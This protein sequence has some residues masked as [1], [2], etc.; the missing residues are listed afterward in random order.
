MVRKSKGFF[1]LTKVQSELTMKTAACCKL[2]IETAGTYLD[3]LCLLPISSNR[4]RVVNSLSQLTHSSS[5]VVLVF[6]VGQS[7]TVISSSYVNCI[8]NLFNMVFIIIV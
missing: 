3:K 4:G 2:E 7:I 6:R 1:G 5:S 8:G